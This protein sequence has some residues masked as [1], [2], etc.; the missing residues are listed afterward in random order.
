MPSVPWGTMPR[1]TRRSKRGEDAEVSMTA[2]LDRI[3]SQ[4]RGGPHADRRA[5]GSRRRDRPSRIASAGLLEAVKEYN[6]AL[7]ADP[8]H[9]WSLFQLGRCY[10]KLGQEAEA[11][12]ALRACV[13]LQP[14]SPWGY[15]VRPG[16]GPPRTVWTMPSGIS[17]RAVK[18]SPGLRLSRLNR[19]YVYWQ[20][21]KYD[22]ALK[23]FDA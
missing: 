9:F 2:A 7:K 15:S 10:M 23:E 14:N 12:E 13:A 20:E 16:P 3:S 17:I 22:D 4:G 11:K 5:R 18:L 1:P 8:D 19:G 21:S 6:A